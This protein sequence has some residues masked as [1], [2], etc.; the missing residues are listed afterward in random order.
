MT[1]PPLRKWKVPKFHLYRFR[2]MGWQLFMDVHPD[3]NPIL[4]VSWW[5]RR[6]DI[7]AFERDIIRSRR[8]K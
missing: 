1:V 5:Q 6:L 8:P 2:D 3:Y 7:R 4:I